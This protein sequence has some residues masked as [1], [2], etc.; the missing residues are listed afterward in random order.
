MKPKKQIASP[1]EPQAVAQ[2]IKLTAQTTVHRSGPLPDPITL[3]EYDDILPGAAERIFLIA[4]KD[5]AFHHTLYL[6]DQSAQHRTLLL[7][8]IFG[9]I[10]G[11]LALAAAV[12]LS[13]NGLGLAGA[14]VFIGAVATLISAAVWAKRPPKKDSSANQQKFRG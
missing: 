12:L 11:V 5:Q 14:A 9:F 13:I 7:G 3:K 1:K 6:R 2:S 4:E 8:Q 10:L